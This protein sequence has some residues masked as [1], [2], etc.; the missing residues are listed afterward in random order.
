MQQQEHNDADQKLERTGASTA[1]PLR[2][3]HDHA[4]CSHVA[5]RVPALY[6]CNRYG[7][8]HWP[9]DL[10]GYSLRALLGRAP[11]LDFLTPLAPS[12]VPARPE[13]C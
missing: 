3:R 6:L 9:L 10:C 8:D 5:G 13:G 1:C 4:T 12:K 11:V 2:V 7:L